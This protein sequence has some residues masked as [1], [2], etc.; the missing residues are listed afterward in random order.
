MYAYD[1]VILFPQLSDKQDSSHISLELL[2][3]ETSLIKNMTKQKHR[4]E[5]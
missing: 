1:C 3:Q 4:G 5:Q 2:T